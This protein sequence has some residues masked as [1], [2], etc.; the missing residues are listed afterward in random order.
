MQMANEA[1]C[2]SPADQRETWL[3][4][5]ASGFLGANFGWHLKDRVHR[6]AMTRGGTTPSHFD[7]AVAALLEYPA[8]M[9]DEVVRLQP[10][11]IVHAAALSSHEQ[12]EGDPAGAR[13]ANA[14]A[15]GHM[16]A[17]AEHVG[18]R[19]VYISTDAVFDGERGH[20]DEQDEPRPTSVYGQTKLLGEE[21]AQ[22][23]TEA[24]VIRTNFFGW[25][26]SGRRSIL[27][28][29]VN[30]LKA[31]NPVRGFTDF[32]TSSA[33]AQVLVEAIGDMLNAQA[34][35][36]FHVTSP[37]SQTKFAFGVA[38]AEEFGLD[39]TLITPIAADIHPPRSGDISL[40]VAKV[41]QLL[42]RDLPTMREGIQRARLDDPILREQ[43][44][45]A[46]HP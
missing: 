3:V 40:N 24:L 45:V 36:V 17:A 6:V 15:T 37:D 29:F 10:A 31:G 38:V 7:S 18:A 41:Q 33:Y 32:T 19:F 46:P 5:G 30:E 13:L 21:L 26:P 34:S 9:A 16:A 1:V 39:P 8:A 35:G 44:T 28:F 11:V 14:T 12:C 4:T 22:Q 25:S 43:L 23:E 42:G 20:Y 2:L 27:E